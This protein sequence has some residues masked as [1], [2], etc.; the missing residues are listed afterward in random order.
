MGEGT[1]RR[2]CLVVVPCTS[3]PEWDRDADPI[4]TV[5]LP[6]RQL[7]DDGTWLLKEVDGVGVVGLRAI[8]LF[9]TLPHP[10]HSAL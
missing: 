9:E 3:E 1:E 4:T 10:E 7:G 6:Q 2:N 8:L 5:R